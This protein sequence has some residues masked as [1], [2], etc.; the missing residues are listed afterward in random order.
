MFVG[1]GNVGK[2]TLLRGLTGHVQVSWMQRLAGNNA[3][4]GTVSKGNLGPSINNHRWI[5]NHLWTYIDISTDGIDICEWK[6]PKELTEELLPG[7]EDYL[8]FNC[9][10][11]AGQEVDLPLSQT[12]NNN[13]RLL[14]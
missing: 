1:N 7:D 12:R 9:W 10:D 6:V 4:Q 3:T 11:F 13:L 14:L 5:F 8:Q 2:T